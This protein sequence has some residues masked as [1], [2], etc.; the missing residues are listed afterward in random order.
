VPGPGVH[1]TGSCL[2]TSECPVT[3]RTCARGLGSGSLVDP[4]TA[5][6]SGIS[7]AGDLRATVCAK[8][9]DRVGA[10]SRSRVVRSGGRKPR[11]SYKLSSSS[12]SCFMR[13]GAGLCSPSRRT[14]GK[15]RSSFHPWPAAEANSRPPR[16]T[17][18]PLVQHQPTHQWRRPGRNRGLSIV[19]RSVN[20]NDSTSR[21][22]AKHSTQIRAHPNDAS[23]SRLL[24]GSVVAVREGALGGSALDGEAAAR[25]ELPL[26]LHHPAHP[27]QAFRIGLTLACVEHAYAV[28]DGCDGGASAPAEVLPVGA[29]A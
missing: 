4:Q 10:R 28:D 29:D 12:R 13:G 3:N 8:G 7:R 20:A 1:R 27:Q 16:V 25:D 24:L 15:R 5:L 23:V 14:V 26:K 9:Q 22:A 2:E 21:N 6:L 17:R 18:S 19:C 11:Y